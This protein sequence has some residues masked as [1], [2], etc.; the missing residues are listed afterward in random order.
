MDANVESK[1][2]TT[3]EYFA[4]EGDTFDTLMIQKPLNLRAPPSLV[5]DTGGDDD[6]DGKM[7]SFRREARK[8]RASRQ[9]A[10]DLTNLVSSALSEV[11]IALED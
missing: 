6:F 3:H 10:Q 9:S 11:E 8:A 7:E 1:F 4:F 5:A 2:Q